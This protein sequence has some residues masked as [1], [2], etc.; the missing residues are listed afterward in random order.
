MRM[1]DTKLSMGRK[2]ESKITYHFMI[3]GHKTITFLVYAFHEGYSGSSRLPSNFLSD[4][5]PVQ[6]NLNVCVGK[7]A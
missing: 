4:L 3:F 1:L 5:R 2:K 6:V 7:F